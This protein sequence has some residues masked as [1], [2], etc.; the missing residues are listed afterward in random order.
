MQETQNTWVQ[1][2]GWEDF[3]EEQMATHS[4]ILSWIIPWT[5]EPDRLQSMV[6]QRVGHYWVTEQVRVY[7][8]VTAGATS[9]KDMWLLW[10]EG[11]VSFSIVLWRIT[12]ILRFSFRSYCLTASG[13]LGWHFHLNDILAADYKGVLVGGTFL[14]KT[15]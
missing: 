4:S 14:H 1:S 3:L 5:E 15:A 6:S 12:D 7:L 11:I 2:L 9:Q 8:K 13:S 10:P